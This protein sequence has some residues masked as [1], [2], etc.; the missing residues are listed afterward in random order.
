MPR[1]S[2]EPER[3]TARQNFQLGE[4]SLRAYFA[5][6]NV[7]FLK[8]AEANFAA[9][10]ATDPYYRNAQFYLGVAKTQ[11]RETDESI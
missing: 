3:K 7:R 11:L 5:G 8:E 6:G 4:R 1:R 2:A 9:L 10:P